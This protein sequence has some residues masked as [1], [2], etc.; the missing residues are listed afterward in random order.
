MFDYG[1][2]KSFVNKDYFSC[3][4]YL[5][6]VN[7]KLILIDPGFYNKEIKDYINKNGEL[8]AV[9]ITHGHWD[10]F[11]GLNN[12]YK[13]F[14]EAEI[15]IHELDKNFLGD[16][17]LNCSNYFGCDFALDQNIISKINT[18]AGEND[19]IEKYDLEIIKTPGHTIGSCLFLF[20]QQKIIF[21]G[22]TV[23]PDGIPSFSFPTGSLDQIKQSW[24][25]FLN[26]DIDNNFLVC[27]GHGLPEKYLEIKN[28]VQNYFFSL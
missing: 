22:D 14:P 20:R 18:F 24:H 21:T 12:I 8:D 13:D 6:L 3:S 28:I 7:R 15:Y 11:Q 4:V 26:L 2:V 10:H 23:M 5:I 27:S 25:K 9:F 16:T 17:R 1:L 19:F